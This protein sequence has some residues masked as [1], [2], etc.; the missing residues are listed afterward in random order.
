LLRSKFRVSSDIVEILVINAL[1][2]ISHLN[3]FLARNLLLSF[4][5]ILWVDCFC[6]HIQKNSFKCL[7]L[8]SF[9]SKGLSFVFLKHEEIRC[10]LVLYN[11]MIIF[12]NVKIPKN[13]NIL[14]KYLLCYISESPQHLATNITRSML[15]I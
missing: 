2:Q 1:I 4:H 12:R 8:F 9:Y 3:L 10:Y 6:Y 11:R 5:I 7:I 15:C 13:Y 14:P